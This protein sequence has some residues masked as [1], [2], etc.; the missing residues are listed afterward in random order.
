[1]ASSDDVE[2][3]LKEER[4]FFTSTPILL[5][6]KISGFWGGWGG[7]GVFVLSVT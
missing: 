5:D 2:K 4:Y 7:E 3:H 6:P 1:M